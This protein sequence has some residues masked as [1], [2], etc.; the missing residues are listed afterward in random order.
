VVGD[1]N[2][3]GELFA[4]AA[5]MTAVW[6][7][8]HLNDAGRGLVGEA[9]W[10]TRYDTRGPGLH[11]DSVCPLFA[12]C[13]ASVRQ[14][15]DPIR[16]TLI[17]KLADQVHVGALQ[18]QPFEL[19]RV[20]LELGWLACDYTVRIRAQ[21]PHN[22]TQTQRHVRRG[23]TFWLAFHTGPRCPNPGLA[24]VRVCA[25]ATDGHLFRPRRHD[26]LTCSDRCRQRL[27]RGLVA[28]P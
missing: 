19:R 14:V 4:P 25:G 17:V 21:L 18:W 16:G 15:L 22:T 12:P 6:D 3:L 7:P 2:R 10:G 5:F 8:P 11:G 20:A 9:D 24:L 1:W 28:R 13:L 26:Q 27:H 23:A